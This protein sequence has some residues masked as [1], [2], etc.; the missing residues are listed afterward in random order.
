MR[1]KKLSIGLRAVL[2]IFAG[3]F[4]AMTASAGTL[5]VLHAFNGAEGANP[6]GV[7][8]DAS[9]NLYGVATNGGSADSGLVYELTSNV[10]G[11]W[12]EEILFDFPSRDPGGFLANP[13]VFDSAGNLY[14]T[15]GLSQDSAG[16]VYELSPSAEG[17]WHQTILHVLAPNNSEGAFPDA[18]VTFDTAGNLYSTAMEGGAYSYRDG[19]VFELSPTTEGG[20][21]D[22][23]LLSLNG[24]D[25]E[26]VQSNVVF[27]ANGN[28]YGVASFGGAYGY[29]TVWELSPQTGG[30]WTDTVLYSFTGGAD[31]SSPSQ[32][33]IFDSAGNLY[34]TTEGGGLGRGTVFELTPSVGSWNETVLYSFAGTDD[35]RKP[36]SPLMFDAV[37]NLYGAT[38]YGGKDDDGVVFKLT[39]NGGG[40]WTE[41]LLASFNGKDGSCPSWT[42]AFDSGGNFYGTTNAGGAYGDGTV[43]EIMP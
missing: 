12:K 41:T 9:G 25:G 3:T 8:F 18:T 35:G 19:T 33:L 32:G 36:L 13:V 34:G 15:T 7:I 26:Y 29:G 17:R 28:L 20:W 40:D 21:I 27:D 42:F 11:Q 4:L 37:G 14:G 10:D 16:M 23:T 22:T 38:C 2:A 5:K 24:T 43:F 1:G 6:S 31:G 39:P 30:T